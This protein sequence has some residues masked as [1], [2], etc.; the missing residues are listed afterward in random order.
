[1]VAG[2]DLRR[3]D[4]VA[5]E[6]CSGLGIQIAELDCRRMPLGDFRPLMSDT[7]Q[8]TCDFLKRL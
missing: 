5:E 6:F 1:L 7:L 4:L 2:E 3:T 8:A